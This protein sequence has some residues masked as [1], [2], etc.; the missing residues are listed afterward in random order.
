MRW[1]FAKQYGDVTNA[2]APALVTRPSLWIHGAS[3][4]CATWNK[5]VDGL[6]LAQT[7]NLPACATDAR[8]EAYADILQPLATDGAVLVGH[9][10]GGM[11]ALELAARIRPAALVLIEAVPTVVDTFAGRIAGR[12][13]P[14][15]LRRI[16]PQRL[17]RLT[18]VGEPE[19]VASELLAQIPHWSA[20]EISHQMTAAAV[21]DGRHLLDQIAAPTLLVRGLRNRATR[22]GMSAFAK[23]IAGSELLE[24]DGGHNLPL[25]MP[26]KLR[27]HIGAFLD[28]KLG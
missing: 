3:L 23:G 16:P 8:V 13:L 12:V 15:V 25:E 28:R 27:A 6:P 9:S 17:A 22:R 14:A 26:E 5:V 20:H 2:A 18:G 1:T 21:F 11:V 24:L 19:I 10:L 7:P 4:T